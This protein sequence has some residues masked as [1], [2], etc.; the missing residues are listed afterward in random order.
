MYVD[1]GWLQETS[2]SELFKSLNRY[3]FTLPLLARHAVFHDN[4]IGI[5][6][7]YLSVSNVG[8]L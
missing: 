3:L 5:I 4:A 1:T 6:S 8:G 7:V 2:L